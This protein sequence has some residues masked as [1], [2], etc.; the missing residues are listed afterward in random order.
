[1]ESRFRKIYVGVTLA[2]DAEGAIRPLGI[3]WTDG[4]FYA[5][6][7]LTQ[8]RLAAS[9]KVGGCG[10]RYTVEIRGR[11]TYLFNEDGRWFVEAREPCGR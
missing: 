2:V 7:R 9:T 1:M 5:V 3:R 6:D 4:S 10:V 8:R 11:K